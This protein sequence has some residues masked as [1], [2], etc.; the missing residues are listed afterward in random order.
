MRDPSLWVGRFSRPAAPAAQP[1]RWRSVEVAVDADPAPPPRVRY[2]WDPETEILTA[3]IEDRREGGWAATAVTLSAA[4]GAW[5]TLELRGGRFCGL[6]VAVWPPVELR[7]VLVTPRGGTGGHARCPAAAGGPPE[8]E[9]DAELRAERDRGG[10]TVRLGVGP[11]RPARPVRVAR[12][13]MLDVDDAGAL[14]G[15]WLL[16][17][18][19]LPLTA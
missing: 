9:V 14:A 13:I 6:E 7:A 3:C 19:P 8:I 18:P 16:N 4:S 5:V 12:D 17:V 10:R 11:P 1:R 15:V 2:Q